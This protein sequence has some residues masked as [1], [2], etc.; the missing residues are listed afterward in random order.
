MAI[1]DPFRVQNDGDNA[2]EVQLGFIF[3]LC[4]R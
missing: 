3:G 2:L 1:G 4:F